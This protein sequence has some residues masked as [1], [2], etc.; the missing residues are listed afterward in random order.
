MSG[1]VYLQVCDAII[2][3]VTRITELEQSTS[4]GDQLSNLAALPLNWDSYGAPPISPNALALAGTLYDVL[5]HVLPGLSVV[6]TTSGGVCLE[7]TGDGVS[8]EAEITAD[9]ATD[10]HVEA[11]RVEETDEQ[12]SRLETTR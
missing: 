4:S 2:D 5:Q 9:D 12:I 7:W 8:V 3:M 1:G 11:A 10:P 6:P